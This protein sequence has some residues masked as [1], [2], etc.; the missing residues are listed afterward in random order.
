MWHVVVSLTQAE[1]G[2][3]NTFLIPGASFC[4]ANEQARVLK[5]I[6]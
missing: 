5:P 2:E 6:L 3:P 1:E 4:V